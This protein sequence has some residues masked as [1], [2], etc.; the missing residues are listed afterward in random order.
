VPPGKRRFGS[1]CP[2]GKVT[3]LDPKNPYKTLPSHIPG[4]N[5]PVKGGQ[6]KLSPIRDMPKKKVAKNLA[7]SLLLGS[8]GR[9]SIARKFSL[10][11]SQKGMRMAKQK[12]KSGALTPKASRISHMFGV[13]TQ[14]LTK[15]LKLGPPTH[16]IVPPRVASHAEM[17]VLR[18][19]R[20]PRAEPHEQLIAEV[21]RRTKSAG[22]AALK[23]GAAVAGYVGYSVGASRA[24]SKPKKTYR[25]V[26]TQTAPKWKKPHPRK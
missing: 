3:R 18:R 11:G 6:A 16:D 1:S 4:A 14:N 10:R 9:A 2:T 24:K 5:I 20:S 15:R 23:A 17:S 26:K 21:D 19:S 8:H 7:I 22:R 13:K 25:A 12:V